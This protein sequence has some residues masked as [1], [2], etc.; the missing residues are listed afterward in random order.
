MAYRS[1][2]INANLTKASASLGDVRE[3]LK[4]WEPEVEDPAKF[5]LR[6]FDQNVLGKSSPRRMKDI[7]RNVMARRYF[8]N[9]S[10]QPAENLRKTI[11]AGLPRSVTDRLLYYHAALAEHLLYRMATELF[12]DLRTR[13]FDSVP[14]YEVEAHIRFLDEVGEK[15]TYSDSVRKRLCQHTLAALRDFT[16]LE[17]KNNKRI[18]PVHIPVEVTGYVVFSLKDEN[19]SSKN[20]TEHQDWRLYLLTATEVERSI[21]EA[22]GK[23]WFSYERAGDIHRFD[24]HIPSLDD[25]VN[26]ITQ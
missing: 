22:A 5:L 19:H 6:A 18:A 2:S 7:V 21:I 14:V 12:Y 15:E 9:S 10:R 3:L 25:Y 23:G 1:R 24:W 11:I 17:G 20:I 13:G 16:I 8:P 26:A 4:L